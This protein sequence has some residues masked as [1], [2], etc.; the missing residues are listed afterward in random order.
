MWHL[1]LYVIVEYSAW[2]FGLP[3]SYWSSMFLSHTT[4]SFL[5]RL[6]R[7]WFLTFFQSLTSRSHAV[8]Y[9]HSMLKLSLYLESNLEMDLYNED[10][11]SGIWI[12][13]RHFPTLSLWWS[14]HYG[15]NT[16]ILILNTFLLFLIKVGMRLRFWKFLSSNRV[17]WSIH[18]EIFRL[19]ARSLVHS[20]L[21]VSRCRQASLF[22][23]DDVL[24][25]PLGCRFVMIW[26]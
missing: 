7:L 23:L 9:R 16:C 15:R 22:W 4:K 3:L 21:G 2:L 25:K 5:R 20:V 14:S 24:A 11:A 26:S 1:V 19:P 17:K 10:M 18:S 6:W 8:C 12:H 13:L